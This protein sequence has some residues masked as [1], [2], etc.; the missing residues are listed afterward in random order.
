M[1]IMTLLKSSA[2]RISTSKNTCVDFYSNVSFN[3]R[4]VVYFIFLT[5]FI[6]VYSQ[7]VRLEDY[8]V[9]SNTR[10][11]ERF[12]A[13]SC[14]P[15]TAL[16]Y[17]VNSAFYCTGLPITPNTLSY[18]GSTFTSVGISPDLPT[19]LSFNTLNG[20]I[21][22]TPT[23]AVAGNYTVI[24]SNPCGFT[25]RSLYIAVSS[26]T[27]YYTDA[28]GDGYGTGTATVSCSGQ[29]ANTATN[30]TDCAPSNPSKW[31][32][33]NLYI[34][35]DGDSY[36]NGF[37]AVPTC[38]G[39]TVPNGYT[40]KYIGIDCMDTNI[41]VN[42]N[43]AEIAGN[44]IDD[45]C[46]GVID[47]ITTTS[48]LIATS[49]G[50]TVPTLSALLYAQPI[51]GAQGYRFEVTNGFNVGVFETNVNRFSLFDL[52]RIETFSLTNS[53]NSVRVSVKIGGFWR[54]YGSSCIV[55]SPAVPNATYVNNP[56]CGSF[57]ADIWNTI[58]CYQIPG[59]TGYRFRV[60]RNGI[61]VG[62]IDK[63]VNNFTLVDLGINNISFA[64][65]YTIDV[66]LKMGGSWLPDTEYGSSCVIVTPPT[67]GVSR[68]S[69][70]SCGSSTNSLWQSIYATQIT[71]AQGYKF[72]FD[73]G[74]RYREYITSSSSMSI[75]NIPGG[76]MVGTTYS[77]RVDVLHNNSYVPGRE[78]C[79]LNILPTA[80]RIAG[81]PIDIFEI[82]S[83]PNPFSSNF[84]VSVNSSR[85]D[86]VEMRVYDMF[87]RSIGYYRDSIA[88]I[89]NL[90][91]GAD[92]PSGV[93]IIVLVQGESSSTL[94]VVKR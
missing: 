37:P 90:E 58:Y 24:I 9:G 54:A 16:N 88:M 35:V 81:E 48:Y 13:M 71:G 8:L 28:D 31:R 39:A 20:T 25:S 61:L 34:D 41:A 33:S 36:H 94:K 30:N 47:E 51:S 29:P 80:T 17:T 2:P 3:R 92:Y 43:A 82:K 75:Q 67:P 83:T 14:V 57:L 66:L 7:V 32:I 45:N 84:Q 63:S 87:G 40:K 19:G 60:K 15:P 26:G 11:Q 59:A 12:N 79:T 49:C 68:I 91:I 46:D 5:S 44:S 10:Q 77:I 86:L 65:S 21:T 85:D 73:N 56:S 53:T 72:V 70:P 50:I 89:E 93:Y 1:I 42:P 22:G 23:V 6:P 27:N 69:F 76:P 4:L 18:L 74:V 78:T 62:T 55:N 64:T 52:S 38:Y